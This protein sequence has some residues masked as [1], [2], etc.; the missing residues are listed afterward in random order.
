MI[1]TELHNQWKLSILPK[2][3]YYLYN[4]SHLISENLFTSNFGVMAF[5]TPLCRKRL[6]SSSRSMPLFISLRWM[7][8]NQA[9]Y[10]LLI[11][12]WLE[13]FSVEHLK[14]KQTLIIKESRTRKKLTRNGKKE[15]EANEAMVLVS[16]SFSHKKKKKK[17][18]TGWKALLFIED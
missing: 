12:T 18:L 14:P 16:F 9:V 8:P 4:N 15:E 17:L 10:D 11:T 13:T 6:L 5:L 7:S 1:W 2:L 3:I